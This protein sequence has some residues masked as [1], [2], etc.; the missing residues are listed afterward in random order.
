MRTCQTFELRPRQRVAV[1]YFFCR[2]SKHLPQKN[3]MASLIP[4][5]LLLG[6]VPQTGRAWALFAF[7]G[8]ETTG[9]FSSH[10]VGF[11]FMRPEQ[12][13]VSLIVSPSRFHAQKRFSPS[14]SLLRGRFCG[15][16]CVERLQVVVRGRHVQDWST[17]LY[18]N[19]E[20]RLE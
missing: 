16:A 12:S 5:E 8:N 10:S 9:D 20:T 19:G 7:V 3:T 2:L 4:L 15:F 6:Q 17:R 13:T 1:C 14:R 18:S 11:V